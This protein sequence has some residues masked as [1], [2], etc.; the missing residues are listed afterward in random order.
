MRSKFQKWRLAKYLQNARGQSKIGWSS[1]RFCQATG[2]LRSGTDEMSI[3]HRQHCECLPLTSVHMSNAS[4]DLPALWT[5]GHTK[6]NQRQLWSEAMLFDIVLWNVECMCCKLRGL[7]DTKAKKFS[8]NKNWKVDNYRKTCPLVAFGECIFLQ[9]RF[10]HRL[11]VDWPHSENIDMI[12]RK[13]SEF[14]LPQGFVRTKSSH[15][16][17]FCDDWNY[18]NWLML[19]DAFAAVVIRRGIFLFS[20][21]TEANVDGVA[22]WNWTIF[23]QFRPVFAI[24][25][26]LWFYYT[27]AMLLMSYV[28]RAAAVG[29]DPC[30]NVPCLGFNKM[31]CLQATALCDKTRF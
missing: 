7:D 17:S 9:R 26:S 25:R 10:A 20:D 11:R 3:W 1:T 27:A 5:P 22:D 4:A 18:L 29:I 8:S 2:W 14:V 12:E 31:V 23:M 13:V 21:L 19:F 28:V 15:A 24:F 6:A 30:R 16:I